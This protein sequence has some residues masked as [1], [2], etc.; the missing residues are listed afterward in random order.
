MKIGVFDSGNGGYTTLGAIRSLLPENEYYYI[1]D[2]KNCPYGTKTQAELIEITTHIAQRLASWG[3]KLVVIACNTATTQCIHVLRKRFPDIIFVGTEPAI[4]LACDAGCQQI[5]LLATPQTAVSRQVNK[6]ISQNIKHQHLYL[7]PCPGLA[8]VI[9]SQVQFDKNAEHLSFHFKNSELIAK[10]LQTIYDELP[11]D[12]KFDAVILG[13]THYV[14]AKGQI[15]TL[16]PKAQL[17]DGNQGV[18]K[19]V[20]SLQQGSRTE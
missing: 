7:Q 6:L 18:A 14:L 2:H 10:K 1:G 4:K 3:A 9:E 20:Q 11:K 8:D 5:L 16:F 19:R 17:F 13:C 15:Q 12:V